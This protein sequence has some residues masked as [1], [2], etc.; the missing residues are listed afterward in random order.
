M[1][2]SVWPFLNLS[3][4]DHRVPLN[5]G[6]SR[7]WSDPQLSCLWWLLLAGLAGGGGGQAA[8]PQRAGPP[9]EWN[10][11]RSEPSHGQ[12]LRPGPREVQYLCRACSPAGARLLCVR[13]AVLE[14]RNERR[15]LLR[16]P[17]SPRCRTCPFPA[18]WVPRAAWGGDGACRATRGGL[19][20]S[21]RGGRGRALRW[22]VAIVAAWFPL[23]SSPDGSYTEEQS[24]EG[25][26]KV[27]ATDFDDEFDEEEP[28]PA[29]G[30]CKALYTF[31]GDPRPPGS[32]LVHAVPSA[33]TRPSSEAFRI[34]LARF[35]L[36]SAHR[37][38]H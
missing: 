15:H 33:V 32:P 34:L 37:H 6:P 29:I 22:A 4:R 26:G 21:G 14:P 25:E 8:G 38:R 20:G 3:L 16:I 9:A 19:G 10:V 36:C 23:L 5:L 11:R 28:L 1:P 2:P 30:T 24:Q 31:E 12:Q 7:L 17:R 18:A 13:V 27:L 35:T